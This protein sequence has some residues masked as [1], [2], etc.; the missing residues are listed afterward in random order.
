[1]NRTIVWVVAKTTFREF[2]RKP[3]AVFWTYGFPVLMTVVLGFAFQPK[4]PA[5]VPVVVVAGAD[6]S[7]LQ[8]AL[9]A[10]PRLH[11][12]VLAAAAAD[13]ALA[14]GRVALLARGT[15]QAPV[16]RA[17]PTRPDAETARMLVERALRD[18][19]DGPG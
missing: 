4:A 19:T 9:Q 17:D 6:T 14:R 8:A 3:E 2:W 16:L 15:P 13:A 5:P 10:S 1:M 11:V 12:E 18:H 7:A